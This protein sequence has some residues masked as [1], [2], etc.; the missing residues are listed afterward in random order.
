MLHLLW[1][2]CSDRRIAG[3]LIGSAAL[4]TL[5]GVL[6][7]VA[8][9]TAVRAAEP[10]IA[11]QLNRVGATPPDLLTLPTYSLAGHV[12]A[13]TLL[14]A[15]AVLVASTLVSQ[16]HRLLAALVL[17]GAAWGPMT[18]VAV[19]LRAGL[20]AASSSDTVWWWHVVVGGAV[21]VVLAVWTIVVTPEHAGG[22]LNVP[23]VGSLFLVVAAVSFLICWNNVWEL[24][25]SPGPLP[26]LGWALLA[27]GLAAIGTRATWRVLVP[28][29]L[30]TAGALGV[31]ALAYLRQGGWP[32]V[33]GWEFNGMESPVI[34]SAR[35]VLVLAVALVPGLLL[36]AAA[37]TGRRL[38]S[39]RA[40][41]P[42]A[43]Q[44]A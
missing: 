32:G 22:I 21:L 5:V 40:D 8:Q 2:L 29:V 23:F 26:S 20:I 24:Q 19:P 14:G 38:A 36:G 15:V 25:E 18:V 37:R 44:A 7:A 17:V 27:A 33:A 9:D 35:V 4:A 34:L 30:L 42:A 3:W 16:G 11:E 43:V 28:A 6:A 31:A 1:K 13:M 12:A 10:M 41:G 39:R